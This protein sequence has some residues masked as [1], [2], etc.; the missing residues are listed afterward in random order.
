MKRKVTTDNGSMRPRSVFIV[1]L[2]AVVG[3]AFAL[4]GCGSSRKT[5]PAAAPAPAPAASSTASS[6][7]GAVG[8]ATPRLAIRAAERRARGT[9]RRVLIDFG[10]N[11]CP[12]CRAL[13]ADFR[14]PLVSHTLRSRYVLVHVYVGHFD[15]NMDLSAQYDHAA[16]IG[17]PALVVLSSTGQILT[18]TSDGSFANARSMTP[19]QVEA[20]LQRWE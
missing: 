12:D 9:S 13:D 5:P 20:F 3:A 18:A 16:S 15:V 2:S 17:I 11:W 6:P 14:S 19:R 10:A 1:A 7:P 4:A 8:R